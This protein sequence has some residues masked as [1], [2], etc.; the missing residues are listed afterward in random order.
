MFWQG[1]CL[2][3]S[4]ISGGGGAKQSPGLMPLKFVKT[5]LVHITC[6]YTLGY[7]TYIFI[8]GV[9]SLHLQTGM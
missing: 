8:R 6:I 1:G 5:L 3:P 4:D 2:A 7:I 9:H